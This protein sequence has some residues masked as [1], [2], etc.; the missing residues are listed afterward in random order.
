MPHDQSS[1]PAHANGGK[2]IG[3]RE[4]TAVEKFK[5]KGL[6]ERRLPAER[7]ARL[8][9]RS[10]GITRS[11]ATRMGIQLVDDDNAPSNSAAPR[12]P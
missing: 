6:A 1:L 11:M 7:I 4:W 10:V 5:L 9:R 8:L 2:R 12:S 3:Y